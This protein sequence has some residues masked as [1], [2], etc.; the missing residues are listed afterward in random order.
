MRVSCPACLLCVLLVPLAAC[1]RNDPGRP[2]G[3]SDGAGLIAPMSNPW[4]RAHVETGT[5]AETQ[6]PP[7][8]PPSSSRRPP[9]HA[10]DSP[11]AQTRLAALDAWIR[12]RPDSLHEI[13][14]LLQDPDPAVRTRA[15]ALWNQSLS[16]GREADPE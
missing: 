9:T 13:S 16:G 2:A 5:A 8:G 10:L 1:D 14:P 12:A 3:Q 6:T 11:A 4:T 15:R 7:A